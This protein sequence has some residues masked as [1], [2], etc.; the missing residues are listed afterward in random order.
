MCVLIIGPLIKP[1]GAAQH[2]FSFSQFNGGGE[3]QSEDRLVFQLTCQVDLLSP[4]L[5]QFHMQPPVTVLWQATEDFTRKW[6]QARFLI[7]QP[8]KASAKEPS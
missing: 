8:L 1:P 5:A 7:G 2:L 6:C 3:R 4:P